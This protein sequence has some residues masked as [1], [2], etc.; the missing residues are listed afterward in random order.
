MHSD[1]LHAYCTPLPF[2]IQ[3]MRH[4]VAISIP[5]A[6][7]VQLVL[8]L[9]PHWMLPS[10]ALVRWPRPKPLQS[11]SVWCVHVRLP[12]VSETWQLAFLQQVIASHE[13]ENRVAS[14]VCVCY[15]LWTERRPFE[16]RTASIISDRLNILSRELGCTLM[17]PWQLA[18][19]VISPN[20]YISNMT[21]VLPY[22]LLTAYEE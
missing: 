12:S 6:H 7:I 22:Q 18:Y 2:Q 11:C 16:K 9:E 3:W 19:R 21:E 5:A 10:L 8:P 20:I 13:A 15:L 17:L 4:R 14:A 1:V